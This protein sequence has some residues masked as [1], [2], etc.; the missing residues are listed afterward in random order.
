MS[1]VEGR[2]LG[3]LKRLRIMYTSSLV[4]VAAI[5][6]TFGKCDTVGPVGGERPKWCEWCGRC[7]CCAGGQCG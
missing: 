1:M 7:E 4:V 6:P 2:D 3:C 5:F